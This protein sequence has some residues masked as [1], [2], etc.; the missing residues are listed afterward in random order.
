MVTVM[1]VN[2]GLSG[3]LYIYIYGWWCNNHLEKMKVNG[4]DYIIYYG[5]NV[6]NHQPDDLI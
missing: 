4:K 3:G 1:M 5:K 6:P 2:D